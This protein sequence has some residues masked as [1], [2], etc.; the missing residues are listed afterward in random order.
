MDALIYH[1]DTYVTHTPEP[2]LAGLRLFLFRYSD[3][4]FKD[5]ELNAKL[6]LY[7]QWLIAEERYE[8]CTYVHQM[9]K[10]NED[11]II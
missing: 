6:A 7:L 1:I 11:T 4:D 2:T 3:G 10:E 9:L 5:S 8:E